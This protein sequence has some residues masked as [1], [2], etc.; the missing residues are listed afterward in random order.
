[1]KNALRENYLYFFVK[2][3]E[4]SLKLNTMQDIIDNTDEKSV[5]NIPSY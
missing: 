2:F 4:M 1:M 5:Q 3:R